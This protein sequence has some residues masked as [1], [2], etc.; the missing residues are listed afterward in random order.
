MDTR[1]DN[2][3]LG[4]AVGLPQ[5]DELAS[6]VRNFVGNIRH[7][8]QLKEGTK[9]I[10]S[11]NLSAL[12]GGMLDRLIEANVNPAYYI[13]APVYI[14]RIKADPGFANAMAVRL[15]QFGLTSSGTSI[16]NNT[17]GVSENMSIIFDK[18]KKYIPYIIGGILVIFVFYKYVLKK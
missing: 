15:G 8:A 1:Q 13:K 11:G 4:A 14:A 17:E 6:A 2:L 10:Q 5:A 7:K 12:N 3:M 9:I 16:D 18:I